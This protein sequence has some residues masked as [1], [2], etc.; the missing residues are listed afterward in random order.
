MTSLGTASLPHQSATF[1]SH[2]E[3]L[4]LSLSAKNNT[5]L[6]RQQISRA[7][8]GW[9]TERSLLSLTLHRRLRAANLGSEDGGGGTRSVN[10]SVDRR[11][12]C[13]IECSGVE[14]E[15]KMRN[16]DFG[17]NVRKARNTTHGTA[18]V[19]HPLSNIEGQQ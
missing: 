12:N 14:R 6:C 13:K 17:A 2:E 16:E 15:Q 3:T 10:L 19:A 4:D 18:Q 1:Y 7:L 8:A 9:L 5:K 11:K